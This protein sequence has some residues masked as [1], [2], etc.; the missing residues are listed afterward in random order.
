M[1]KWRVVN[2]PGIFDTLFPMFYTIYIIEQIKTKEGIKIML[3]NSLF[4]EAGVIKY[5]VPRKLVAKLAGQISN[6][7]GFPYHMNKEIAFDLMNFVSGVVQSY[8]VAISMD[9][10]GDSS[11]ESFYNQGNELELTIKEILKDMLDNGIYY[12]YLTNVILFDA[13]QEARLYYYD[14]D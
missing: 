6:K 2:T 3:D 5:I 4:D 9:G 7:Y 10:L 14:L 8:D 13:Y 11:L 12:R 1:L